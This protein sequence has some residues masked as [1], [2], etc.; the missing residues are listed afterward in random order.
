MGRPHREPR[1]PENDPVLAEVVRLRNDDRATWSD[2]GRALRLTNAGAQQMYARYYNAM[3]VEPP[4]AGKV[5]HPGTGV[6]YGAPYAGQEAPPPRLAVA[7]VAES[8]DAPERA[9]DAPVAQRIT[10]KAERRAGWSQAVLVTSDHHFDH[11][12]CDRDLLRFHLEQARA[13]K[14]GVLILGDLFCA[15]QG[16][17]DRRAGKPDL[18][19]EYLVDAYAD[20]IVDDAIDWYTPY[21]DLIWLISYG[22]HESAYQKH[23]ETDILKRLHKGLSRVPGAAPLLGTYAGWLSFDLDFGDDGPGQ[24][25]RMRYHHGWGGGGP[26]T[27]GTIG[28]NRQAASADYDIYAQGH[29]HEQWAVARM[30]ETVDADGHAVARRVPHI[31]AG[32]YKAEGGGGQ[33]WHVEGGRPL[34]PLG[35]YWLH[36]YW[37]ERQGCVL[38]KT[39]EVD[40]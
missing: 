31:C 5:R 16:R 39:E 15:M 9:P 4:V 27:L 40:L 22:N 18:R 11:V 30:R 28:T 35:G 33:G 38:P 10:I 26:V 17:M 6:V 1:T 36:L 29:I 32:T 25:L 24:R 21:A 2:I 7:G 13:R 3:G 23:H 34:K 8:D 14:A 20:A 12:H 19:P 37:S